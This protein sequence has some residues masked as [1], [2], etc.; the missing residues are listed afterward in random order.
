MNLSPALQSR[1]NACCE[2]CTLSSSI[3]HSYIVPTRVEESHENSVV[4]CATCFEKVSNQDLN[5]PNYFH[6][7]TGSIWSEIPSVKV[8]SYKLLNQFK[9]TEWAQET[10]ES[11][12]LTE[13]ELAWANSEQ[14]AQTNAI[15][16]KDAYGTQLENG[17]TIF[18]TENLNVKGANFTAVKGTKVSKIRLVP[19]NAEQIEG[20][21]EGTV[22]VILTKF[23]R[24]GT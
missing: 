19:D 15:I 17:D 23:V 5:N 22:I 20:K 13:A 16:H 10:V 6:F 2:L 1:S 9:D 7:L 8:L 12:Y 11:A 18:L 4:L 21:I 24:K 14:D 3:L